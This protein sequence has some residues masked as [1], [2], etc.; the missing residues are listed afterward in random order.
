MPA[1]IQALA[2]SGPL[3]PFLGSIIFPNPNV[4][5]YCI[6]PHAITITAKAPAIAIPILKKYFAYSGRVGSE[7]SEN[8][9]IE[10]YLASSAYAKLAPAKKIPANKK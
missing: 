9:K 3:F 6:P 8:P 1:F 5:I 10:G 4:N 7:P 2:S